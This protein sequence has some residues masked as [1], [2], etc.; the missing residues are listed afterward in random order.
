MRMRHLRLPRH[1]ILSI[2]NSTQLINAS[3][4]IKKEIIDLSK[5]FLKSSIFRKTVRF[6]RKKRNAD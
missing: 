4:L 2:A 3:K 1:L 6:G 5:N